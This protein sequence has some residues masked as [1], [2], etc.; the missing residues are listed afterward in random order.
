MDKKRLNLSVHIII[1]ML[2][3][4]CFYEDNKPPLAKIVTEH[5]AVIGQL[6]SLDGSASSDPNGDDITYHWIV[7]KPDK[8]QVSVNNKT[9]IKFVPDITGNYDIKLIV[10]DGETDALPARTTITVTATDDNGK[11]P[12]IAN[13]GSNMTVTVGTILSLDG[14]TSYDPAGA[15]LKYK[16][17]LTTPQGSKA[18]F[19]NPLSAQPS[20]KPD[21]PG[22]YKARLVVNDGT[23]DSLPV[24]I[25]ITAVQSNTIGESQS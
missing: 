20:F 15:K 12:P 10:N 11:S 7:N 21:F 3:C 5:R 22:D 23:L 6:V 25:T 13:A 17:E 4:S 8:S 9:K 14:S 24:V 18:I 19:D 2:L 1:P 16:W